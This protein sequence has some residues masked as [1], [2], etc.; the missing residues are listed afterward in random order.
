MCKKVLMTRPLP[1]QWTAF[2]TRQLDIVSNPVDKAMHSREIVAWANEINPDA[3]ACCLTDKLDAPTIAA[4]PATVNM[5]VTMASGYNNID[6]A[7]CSAKGIRVFNTP[8]VM[9]QSV[10]DFVFAL[11]LSTA[12]M[13]PSVSNSTA[14]GQWSGWEMIPQGVGVYGKTIGIIGM[15]GIGEKVARRARL[16]FDMNVL[17]YN[18]HPRLDELGTFVALSDLLRRSDFVVLQ[19]PGNATTRNLITLTHLRMMKPTAILIN[20][21]RGW[22]VC[23]AD[24]VTALHTRLIR[25]AAL[26]VF[27]NEPEIRDELRAMATDGSGRVV[28]TPHVGS[29]TVEA[30]VACANLALR[31]I[32]GGGHASVKALNEK[33]VPR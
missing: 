19:V 5:I 22:V 15:G 14:A 21:A 3:I 12:R 10:A 1:D 6:L 31:I 23:E 30:R 9:D 32:R 2:D 29:S 4:L 28:M 18:T 11:L 17:Y 24:L 20:T 26:D 33:E 16:G 13:I 25:A 7:A 8:H 27:E